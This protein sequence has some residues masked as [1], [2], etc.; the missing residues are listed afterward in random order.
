MSDSDGFDAVEFLIR[1]SA[2]C[3][4]C[5]VAKSRLPARDV[6]VALRVLIRTKL[7][8]LAETC[9]SCRG[10]MTAFKATVSR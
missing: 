9:H 1:T 7:A 10:A 3:T 6:E 8:E 2:L 5:L 4:A